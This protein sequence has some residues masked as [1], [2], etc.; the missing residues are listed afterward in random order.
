[1]I[2]EKSFAIHAIFYSFALF[3]ALL[4]AKASYERLAFGAGYFVTFIIGILMILNVL[5][6]ISL[7]IK[8]ALSKS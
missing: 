4:L 1:L 6:G 7:L 3:V 8:D 5:I 2:D